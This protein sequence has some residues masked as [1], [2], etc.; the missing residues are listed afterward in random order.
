MSGLASYQ[1]QTALR[2][3]CFSSDIDKRQCT[4][5]WLSAGRCSRHLVAVNLILGFLL[6]C[7]FFSAFCIVQS[8]RMILWYKIVAHCFSAAS[9]SDLK[10]F[11]VKLLWHS[12]PVRQKK[13]TK[14]NQTFLRREHREFKQTTTATA[15]R[16]W[17]TRSNWKNNSPAG[18]FLNFVRIS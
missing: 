10:R 3:C 5:D 4:L 8:S 6:Y 16:T 11:V 17:K 1:M 2:L 14:W 12:W 13:R 9:I 18:A 15:T 7:F